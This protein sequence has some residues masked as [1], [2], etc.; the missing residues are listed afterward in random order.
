[1]PEPVPAV[2]IGGYLGAGKT[3]LV[4]HLLHAEAASADGRPGRR[5]AV[6]VNDFGEI[7]IDA[8]L[9]QGV[10]AGVLSLAGGCVCCSFGADLVG[11][12]AAVLRR[13][14]VPDVVLVET[15][16]V[17]LP[18]AVARTAALVPG[19]TVQ[20]C[21]LVAD[22]T[23]VRTQAADRYVGDLVRQ[24]LHEADLLLLSKLDL[25]DEGQAA[26]VQAWLHGLPIAAPCVPATRGQVAS[27][28]VLGVRWAER[29]SADGEPAVAR[30]LRLPV[31]PTAHRP[32]S[33]PLAAAGLFA[34]ET[35]R[36]AHAV[37]V[38][39]LGRELL[40]AGALR[41]K[42]V[43]LDERCGRWLELQLA[44]RRLEVKPWSAQHG[45]VE[46]RLVSI[47]LRSEVAR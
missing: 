44:G 10:D 9:I 47:Y 21:V 23:T 45:R 19:L 2:V 16:G 46:G 6:L 11:T 20:G 26:A 4:N 27:D 38:Q 7:A 37:D 40:A 43:L 15:S 36:F 22:A 32:K 12:L 3:T 18:A 14:P 29:D 30:A 13:T 28:V 35:R 24:Q 39:A 1:M 31:H 17:G 33:L 42:G 5:I 25:L 41:A 8:D 34:A